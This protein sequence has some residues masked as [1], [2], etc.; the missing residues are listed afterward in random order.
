MI[1]AWMLYASAVTAL[2]GI[3]A[4]AVEKSMRLARLPGRWI[5]AAAIVGA[6]LVPIV[7][8][9]ESA[10]SNADV[11]RLS[12]KAPT[13]PLASLTAIFPD[14]TD[15][16][17]LDVPLVALWIGVT[18]LLA[19]LLFSTQAQ[20][21]R[22]VRAYREEN[23]FGTKV[24]RS[25]ALGPAVV[26]WIKTAIVIPTWVDD[27]GGDSCALMVSHE[28][29]HLR[30]WDAQLLSTA[31]FL[32]ILQ[33]WNLPLWGV[34][35]RLRRSIELDCDQRVLKSG[36]DVG[37]YGDLL[38]EMSRRRMRSALPIVG[39]AVKTS[40]L[41]RRVETM[42]VHMSA[43]RFPKALLA[44]ALGGTFAAV[45][46]ELPAPVKPPVE[47]AALLQEISVDPDE[48]DA[49]AAPSPG[50]DDE[51]SLAFQP[52]PEEL[53]RVRMALNVNAVLNSANLS[54]LPQ[55]VVERLRDH[56]LLLKVREQDGKPLLTLRSISEEDIE[57]LLPNR[58]T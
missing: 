50:E 41:A 1:A 13:A 5:L 12:A 33:P 4:V 28:R 45:A 6:V 14:S 2:L 58:G 54:R 11:V 9:S 34:L 18:L 32:V 19:V 47:G 56:K 51:I 46:C 20:L 22:K 31:V 30:G 37:Q 24:L 42:T 29:E 7:T 3:G 25:S 53:R 39:F 27:V 17:S 10:A 57:E 43:F 44:V 16:Q 49:M 38:L 23:L 8:R 36:V 26:G 15:L 35:F 21:A 40:F 52:T 48:S 55:G